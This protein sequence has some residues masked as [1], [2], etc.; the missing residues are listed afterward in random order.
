MADAN[1]RRAKWFPHCLPLCLFGS[2][3]VSLSVCLVPAAPHCLCF[4]L[5]RSRIVC[6]SVCLAPALSLSLSH[7]MC[8][9]LYACVCSSVCLSSGLSVL[10]K[11][12]IDRL[13]IY[14]YMSVWFFFYRPMCLFVCHSK[15]RCTLIVQILTAIVLE[16]L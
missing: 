14:I 16:F 15:R 3:I 10:Q 13:F 7:C 5:F 4:C 1:G 12:S 2:F 8:G 6:L 11:Y 9:C